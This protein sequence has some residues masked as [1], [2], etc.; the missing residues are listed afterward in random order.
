MSATKS[1][2]L[3]VCGLGR[4]C[5]QWCPL[6]SIAAAVERTLIDDMYNSFSPADQHSYLCSVDPD[7]MAHHEPSDQSTL[8]AIMLLII[9]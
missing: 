3:I 7:E 6:R 4:H 5:S 2:R 8:F 9:E 1:Y